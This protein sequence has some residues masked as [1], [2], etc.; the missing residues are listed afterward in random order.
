MMWRPEVL[1]LLMLVA[2]YGI[3]TEFSHPGAVLP[4]VAGFIALVLVLY[5]SSILPINYAGVALVL[6]GIGLFI[7]EAFTGASGWLTVG[8]IVSFFF[9]LLML[10]DRNEPAFRL[11]LEFII[12]A[13]VITAAFF[14]FVVAAGLRAQRLPT[15]TGRETL[16]GKVVSAVTP[17]GPQGGKVFVEGEYW[18]AVSPEPIPEG[19]MVK[20]LAVHGL[21]LE[22]KPNT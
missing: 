8:G 1:T 19:A 4:G 18:N 7:A 20:I 17:I 13:T 2:I 3:I 12:P 11:S 14:L 9:G 22:V 6:L 5:M 16:I 15:K 10:F 21:T